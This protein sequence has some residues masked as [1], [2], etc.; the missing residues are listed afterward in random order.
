MGASSHSGHSLYVPN[1]KGVP[2]GFY[3]LAAVI[4]DLA[5]NYGYMS[6]LLLEPP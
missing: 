4:Y 1:R 6:A 3:V 2:G 5:F